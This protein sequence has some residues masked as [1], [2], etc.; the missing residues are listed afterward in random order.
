[1]ATHD[2]T[3]RILPFRRPAT[4]ETEE[5]V[6]LR[7]H[8]AVLKLNDALAAQASAMEGWRGASP[9]IGARAAKL[10]ESAAD[11]QRALDALT[12]EIARSQAPPGG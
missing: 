4:L 5:A 3:A 1:M 8:Q 9:D 7:L 10:A 6:Q 2:K 12:A 11:F